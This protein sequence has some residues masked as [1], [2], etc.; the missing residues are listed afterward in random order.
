MLREM[1][2]SL[3]SEHAPIDTVRAM[4]DDPTGY[5]A[6]LW[7]QLGEVEL[8]GILIPEEYGG[9]GM[10]MLEGAILY[11]E[12]GRSLAPTPHFVSAV[13]GAGALLEAGS[14]AQKKSWLPRV[15]SGEAILTP[16]WL[17]PRAPVR[18]RRLG[19]GLPPPGRRLAA[20]WLPG[21]RLAAA[22]PPP[23]RRLLFC[24]FVDIW[25]SSFRRSSFWGSSF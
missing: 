12:L 1:V 15:A 20:A 4:E 5:P 16:A 23:G 24:I 3:C 8:L 17:E 7:K 6:E 2:R 13:L 9:S 22:W 19:A 10:G 21:R 11:E 18:P 14:E 25:S